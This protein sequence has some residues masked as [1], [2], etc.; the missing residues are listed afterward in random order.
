MEE[1]ILLRS[2]AIS[3]TSQVRI[4]H[5]LLSIH[6]NVKGFA[7]DIEEIIKLKEKCCYVAPSLENEL[8]NYKISE[9]TLS[10]NRKIKIKAEGLIAGESLFK[11]F[12]RGYD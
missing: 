11:P 6:I 9:Y 8:N 1:V 5:Y 2:L 4:I 7:N 3:F 10:D 12:I